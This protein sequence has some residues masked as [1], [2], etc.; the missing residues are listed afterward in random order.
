MAYIDKDFYYRDFNGKSIPDESFSRLADIASDVV[1]GICTVKPN[2]QDLVTDDFK[3]AV[4]YQVE[5]LNEQGGIDAILG[6]SEAAQ[7]C[8]SE[9][10]GDYS[11][12]PGTS[13]T[14]SIKTYN[15]IPVSAMAYSKLQ[16]LG[17][18]SNWA[19][20]QYYRNNGKK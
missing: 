18:M 13:E 10:L 17:L 1:H 6:F 5:M 19:Y 11:I 15:G 20:A 14:S 8:F 4:C 3:K 2:E 16:K 12:S 7:E 9:S